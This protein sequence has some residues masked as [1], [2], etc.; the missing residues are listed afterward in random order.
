MAALTADRLTMTKGA[1]RRQGYKVAAN[2]VIFAGAMVAINAAGFAVPA[3][4]VAG[5]SR[6]VGVAAAKV[7]NI[8]GSDGTV[9][10][11]VEYGGQFLFAVSGITQANVGRLAVV[12]DDQTLTTAATA[13]QD[14]PIG[15]I[16]SLAP[17]GAWVDILANA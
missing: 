17:T 16:R 14:I 2:V 6:V 12:A 1:L 9:D 3:A 8:G 11:V 4:D 15:L 13:T 5:L 7:N 10:V